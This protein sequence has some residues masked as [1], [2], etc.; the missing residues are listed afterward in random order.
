MVTINEGIQVGNY[1]AGLGKQ[2]GEYRDQQQAKQ[3]EADMWDYVAQLE[4]GK[5][6]EAVFEEDAPAVSTGGTKGAGVPVAVPKFKGAK[7]PKALSAAYNYMYKQKMQ[8]QTR[9]KAELELATSQAKMVKEEVIQLWDQYNGMLKAG[10][11]AAADEIAVMI[12]NKYPN[13]QQLQYDKATGKVYEMQEDNNG[14]LTRGK[15]TSLP[16]REYINTVVKG[17]LKEGQFE[18]S[19]VGQMHSNTI[20]NMDAYAKSVPVVDARGNEVGRMARYVNQRTGEPD[21]QFSAEGQKGTMPWS[22]AVKRGYRVQSEYLA[23][24]KEKAG[25]A[26]INAEVKYRS[27]RAEKEDKLV[28]TQNKSDRIKLFIE[29]K[30]SMEAMD[31]L[32]QEDFD[33][34]L[35]KWGL[36]PEDVGV[37]E[38]KPAAGVE[39]IEDASE[40]KVPVEETADKKK[41]S[42]ADKN[43]EEKGSTTA[44]EPSAEMERQYLM[45]ANR[46]GKKEA[47]ARMIKLYPNVAAFK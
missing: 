3:D 46:Y 30:K 19:F 42:E 21:W 40:E 17:M 22:E 31:D 35:E 37:K 33:A 41:A 20:Y 25:I 8:D 18:K 11:E 7:N 28:K 27:E 14:N 32:T 1:F 16:P 29:E 38:Q 44:T 10:R 36:T 9:R 5:N 45:L 26:N 12:Y 34:L 24:Q 15:E 47:K 43:A 13:G 6:P 39:S 4:Q 2:V 23:V